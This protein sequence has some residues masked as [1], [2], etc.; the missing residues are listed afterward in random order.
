[1]KNAKQSILKIKSNYN[2]KGEIMFE[3][4]RNIKNL[5]PE[6]KKKQRKNFEEV[7]EDDIR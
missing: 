5:T 6:E 7:K 4:Q 1:M 3:N 2:I